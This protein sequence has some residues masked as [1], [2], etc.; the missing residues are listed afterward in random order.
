MKKILTLCAASAAGLVLLGWSFVLPVV[1][2][3]YLTGQLH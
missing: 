3:L 1:G 2:L